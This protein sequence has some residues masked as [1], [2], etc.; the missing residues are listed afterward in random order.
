MIALRGGVDDVPLRRVPTTR[1]AQLSCLPF[2]RG[3]LPIFAVT[4]SPIP[5]S[6]TALNTA[7]R[8]GLSLKTACST[9]VTRAD[10]CAKQQG[11]SSEGDLEEVKERDGT[12]A[13]MTPWT[14]VRPKH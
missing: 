9:H 12:T 1:E 14:D 10:V 7:R 11:L 6:N 8:P 4:G 3:L 5:P 13:T 2:P